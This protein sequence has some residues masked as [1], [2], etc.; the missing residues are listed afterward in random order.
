MTEVTLASKDAWDKLYQG[1]KPYGVSKKDQ[2]AKWIVSQLPVK[3]RGRALEVG[4]FPGRYLP[5]IGILGYQLNGVDMQAGVS[6]L[7]EWLATQGY[8]VGE[9]V[10]ADFFEWSPDK[11]FDLVFSLGF[12]EHFE[13][14]EVVIERH[15]ELVAPNGLIM[16]EAPNFLGAFQNWFHRTFDADNL[17]M[18]HVPAMDPFQWAEVVRRHGFEV[19]FCGFFGRFHL[20]YGDEQRGPFKKIVL[21]WLMRSRNLLKYILPSRSRTFSPYAGL[22]ARRGK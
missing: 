19:M 14:W 2:I 15:L 4:C 21:K 3:E 7:P 8:K 17:A 20:W 11:A 13:N 6:E 12:V 10:K 18:H 22:I 1:K 9:F 5:T 16:L